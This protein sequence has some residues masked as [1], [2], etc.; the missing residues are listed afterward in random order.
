MTPLSEVELTY[1]YGNLHI[2]SKAEQEEVLAIVE[3]LGRRRV[4][5]RCRKD[6][7]A[8]C[9]YMQPDYQVGRHHQVLGD[10]LME[11]AEGRKDRICVNIPPRHG[12]SQ[13]VSIYFPAWFLG[14]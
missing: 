9:Q 7:I 10:L 5:E 4:A 2:L 11:I 12:K 6:L 13:L 14:K 3:E 1:L 8:F